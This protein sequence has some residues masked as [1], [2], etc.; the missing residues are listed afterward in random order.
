MKLKEVKVI[1]KAEEE[2]NAKKTTR[3]ESNLQVIFFLSPNFQQKKLLIDG[4]TRETTL[5][6]TLRLR[7]VIV[8]QPYEPV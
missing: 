3:I 6:P 2:E 8:A 1:V 5:V 7:A 4:L